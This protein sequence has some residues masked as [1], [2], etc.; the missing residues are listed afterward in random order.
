[1]STQTAIIVIGV[2]ENI[3]VPGEIMMVSMDF[4]VKPLKLIDLFCFDFVVAMVFNSVDEN[5]GSFKDM[6]MV[7]VL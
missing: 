6:F 2:V 7:W 4:V 5:S 3:A 1:M